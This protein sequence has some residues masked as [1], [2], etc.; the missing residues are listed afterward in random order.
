M[1]NTLGADEVITRHKAIMDRRDPEKRIGLF[2]DEWGTWWDVEEGTN[3]SFLYQQN[4]LRDAVSA[5]LFLNTFNQHCDRV[6]MANIAQTN[7]VLQAMTLTRGT[8]MIVTPTYHVFDMFKV[9]QGA[10][11]LPSDLT[12]TNYEY[13]DESLPSLSVSASRSDDGTINVT[14]CNIDPANGTTLDL[15]FESASV[16]EV[17]GRVLT[18]PAM[19][20]HNTFDEPDAV[21]PVGLDSVRIEGN[22]VVAELPARSVTVLA[23]R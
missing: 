4:T 13:E 3:P 11:Y 10:T 16:S 20:T 9:H 22:A 8:E 2:V 19:N 5:G 23:M 21:K 12:C 17:K 1:K 15:V 18:A 7:N 6:R 14:I